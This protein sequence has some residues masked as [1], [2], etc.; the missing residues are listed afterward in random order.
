MSGEGDAQPLLLEVVGDQRGADRMLSGAADARQDGPQK[1]LKIALG[2]A[3]KNEANPDGGIADPEY[4]VARQDATERAGD[5][6]ERTADRAG[7]AE[8]DPKL[9][10]AAAQLAEN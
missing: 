8:H 10:V 7:H 5:K 4:V 1:E 6:L 9:A 3:H 2:Q